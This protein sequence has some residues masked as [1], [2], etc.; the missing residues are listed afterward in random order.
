M[1][2]GEHQANA[3]GT[4]PTRTWKSQSKLISGALAVLGL[5]LTAAGAVAVFTT[6]NA[7]AGALLVIGAILMLFGAFGDRLESLRYGDLE[8]V[9]RRK[10]D[11]AAGRG[12]SEA[13]E[14]LQRAADTVGQRVAKVAHLYGT[15]RGAMPA[16]PPRT[17]RMEGLITEARR[18]ARATDL[19][20]EEVLRL[21]WTGSEGARVWALGVLQE[22]PELA[23]TRVVLEAVQRPDQMFDQY[24]ALVLAERFVALGTTGPWARAR[25]AAAVSGRL[26]SGALG[27]D[28]DCHDAAERVIHDVSTA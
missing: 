28:R 8:L 5:G 7:G 4:S 9:L 20:A 11:E 19:D 14:I 18:D 22:R 17:A 12:D 6:D 13:A 24:Q 1:V 2:A 16:G 3:T 23:T 21:A 27:T 25:I 15:V 10:A 26:E